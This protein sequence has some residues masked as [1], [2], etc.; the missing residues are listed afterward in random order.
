VRF[1]C[2]WSL[3]P[4]ALLTLACGSDRVGSGRGDAAAN[5][6]SFAIEA[7]GPA[8][9]LDGPTATPDA[10]PADAGA[11]AADAASREA[12]PDLAADL[13]ATLE[14]PPPA[15]DA[16]VAAEAPPDRPAPD[17]AP[18][19]A[20]DVA[21]DAA[22]DVAP[23]AA[24]SADAGPSSTRQTARPIGTTAAANGFYEY[25]PP[26][27][28]DG[29]LRPLMTFWHGFDQNGTGDAAYLTRL[30]TRG[31]PMLIATNQWPADR[32]FVVLSPQHAGDTC[33]PSDEIKN[34]ITFALTHYQVDPKRV[35]FTGL[36][37]GASGG[38]D[39]LSNN[40]GSQVVAAVLIA[41]VGNAAWTK[42][43]CSLGAV[44]I[45]GFHGDA[46]SINPVSGTRDPMN[47]LIACPMP[48][49]RDARLTIYPGVGHDSWTQ[50]YDL[51]AGHDIYTWML[52]QSR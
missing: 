19:A 1:P 49:R 18:D 33:P 44:A 24:P 10:A 38:W 43:G 29:Q 8:S 3:L 26:G 7:D 36:S 11:S 28:G 27:Y 32:P 20:P 50:T 31:P 39:Y 2:R 48:P 4:I 42:A 52:G 22:P 45:W 51:S 37:C 40:L 47:A 25:L 5:E 16:P 30:L 41:G 15:P 12:A 6:A 35:Y 14:A 13:P 46:D 21:P 9:F 23:D 34:F 17:V